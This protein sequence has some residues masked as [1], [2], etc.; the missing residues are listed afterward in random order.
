MQNAIFELPE[1]LNTPERRA[2]E[3]LLRKLLGLPSR[4]GVALFHSYNL[5]SMGGSVGGWVGHVLWVLYGGTLGAE[6]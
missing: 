3:R 1:R 5:H 4:P 2:L 6:P